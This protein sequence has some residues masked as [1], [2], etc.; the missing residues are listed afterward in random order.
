[1]NKKRSIWDYEDI[2]G[3]SLLEDLETLAEHIP[4]TVQHINATYSGGGVAEILSSMIPLFVGLGIETE[5][6]V[7]RGDDDFFSVT[8][9]FHNAL[10]GRAEDSIAVPVEHTDVSV[11]DDIENQI[12]ELTTRKEMFETFLRWNRINAEEM[13][14]D[15]DYMIIHDPQPAALIDVKKR[16]KWVW[17]CHIDVSNPDPLVWNFL[18]DPVSKYDASVFSTP[19]FTRPDLGIRMARSIVSLT[20]TG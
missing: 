18:R 8:K 2:V 12:N 3:R 15:S 13:E 19:L 1:M 10:H 7:I 5:W 20:N 6:N 16:G 11:M 17:R 4:G 14:L 9:G